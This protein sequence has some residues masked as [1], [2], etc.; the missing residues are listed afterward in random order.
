MADVTYTA[1]RGGRDLLFRIDG[2]LWRAGAASTRCFRDI[3]RQFSPELALATAKVAAGLMP[4]VRARWPHVRAPVLSAGESELLGEA[5]LLAG[6]VHPRDVENLCREGNYRSNPRATFDL[7]QFGFRPPGEADAAN[8]PVAP[9]EVSDESERPIEPE[10]GVLVED[11][12]VE[13]Q[14]NTFIDVR[15]RLESRQASR[16]EHKLLVEFQ[17][18]LEATGERVGAKKIRMGSEPPLRTD[19]Y[20]FT[21]KQLV[22]AKD[23]ASREKIRMALG[24]LLDYG[25]HVPHDERAVLLPQRPTNDLE[26]LLKDHDVAIVWRDGDGFLDNAGGAFV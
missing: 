14:T 9:H 23:E 17:A 26:Q 1:D 20:N 19:L 10:E 22:E 12:E 24:Q 16:F 8:V 3:E 11:T 7:R 4:D 13:K 6:G 2:R 18:Y 25:R 21:R 15:A 5:M